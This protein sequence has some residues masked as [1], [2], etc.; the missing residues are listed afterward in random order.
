[1]GFFEKKTGDFLVGCNYIKPKD[2]HGHL[3]DFLSQVSKLTYF[4]GLD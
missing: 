1:V 2:N 3:I 4:E